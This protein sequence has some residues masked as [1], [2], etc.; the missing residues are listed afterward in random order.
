MHL[1]FI[2]QRLSYNQKKRSKFKVIKDF[3]NS[4]IR[5]HEDD[6]F[7]GRDTADTTTEDFGTPNAYRRVQN[8]LANYRLYNNQL[9]QSDFKEYCDTL[10]IK[11]AIGAKMH[12][13]KPYNK[14]YNKVN[15]LLG[16]EYRRPDTQRAV[17]VNPEG[18]RSK[19]AYKQFLMREYIESQIQAEIMKVK[20]IYGN[21]QLE[22]L[23]PEQQQAEMQ[24][25]EEEFQ[26]KMAQIIPP[27]SI[28]EFMT[29][30]YLSQKEITANDLLAYL[31]LKEDIKEKK[32]DGFKHGM[33][34]GEEHAWVGVRNGEAV[35]DI[36][37]PLKVFYHKSPEVKYVQDGLYA[38]YRTDMTIG[39]VLD[40]F[41]DVLSDR[42]KN[43][44]EERY[45]YDGDTDEDL[46]GKSMKYGDQRTIE[47]KYSNNYE[48]YSEG[49][50]GR[51]Y[52]DDIEVVHME[53]VSQKKV[54][55]LEYQDQQGETQVMKIDEFFEVPEHATVFEYEDEMGLK[56]K[57]YRWDNFALEWEW[58]PEVWEATR[59]DNDL[60]GYIGPKKNQYYSI[61]NPF[62]VKLGYYG[63]IYNNMNAISQ[64]LVDRMKPYQYL[65]FISMDK[66][67]TLIAKD[68]GTILTID[69]SK[70]DPKFPIEKMI[71][72]IEQAGYYVSNELQG[73]DNPGAQNRSGI[74]ALNASNIGHIQAFAEILAYFDEQIGDAAGV[75][76]QREGGS[77]RYEAVGNVQQSILQSSYI[78]E[79]YFIAHE[80]LW[81]EIKN[82][83]LQCAQIVYADNP[84]VTQYILNDGSRTFLEIDENTFQ[85]NEEFGVFISDSTRDNQIFEELRALTQP[86]LQNDKVDVDDIISILAADS[87][88]ELKKELRTAKMRREKRE[89]QMQQQ[90]LEIQKQ[91]QERELE[92]REDQQA[93]EIELKRMEIE[94]DLAK[95]E[96]DATRFAQAQ[97]V[98]ENE[99]PDRLE[100]E[101][102][103]QQGEMDRQK[104]EI[105]KEK[106]RSSERMN[107]Q[108]NQTKIKVEKMKP[109]PSAGTKK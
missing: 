47:Y 34:S 20:Q 95:A 21:P 50:Y 4:T 74:A 15:V 105:E 44:L 81:K 3:V 104:L 26:Q 46:I 42:D 58:I 91:M 40:N 28:D 66:F 45:T 84:L 99:I 88:E 93:H 13:I 56:V 27:D 14:I 48:I 63:L 108:N 25:A 39:D 94:G 32:N 62:K 55:F 97:D 68:K 60:W 101:K 109:K 102:V 33:I 85:D 106:I 70:L 41:A 64:S 76:K 1:H 31:Y 2:K 69:S 35:V 79:P 11:D 52:Y 30:K 49:S 96:I 65:F 29:T 8:M 73:S 43:R 36:L 89:E 92:F 16:E 82:G 53:W 80:H 67:K 86:L 22:G 90:Q 37:N 100:V 6:F 98:N 72:F 54:G 7:Y 9:D 78:T 57:S 12:D 59:I 83:L 17:L 38:G 23:P 87:P 61:N 103:R 18:V 51:S 19:M 24:R 75:T 10:G 107:T 77:Q 71:H 5:Y